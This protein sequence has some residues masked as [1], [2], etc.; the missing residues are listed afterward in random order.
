MVFF[1]KSIGQNRSCRNEL[2]INLSNVSTKQQLMEQ[3]VKEHD[4]QKVEFFHV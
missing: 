1:G 3:L 2:C 4:I